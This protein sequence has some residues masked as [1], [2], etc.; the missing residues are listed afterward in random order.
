MCSKHALA[1]IASPGGT[2]YVA[3]TGLLGK[4]AGVCAT[5]IALLRSYTPQCFNTIK[6][7]NSPAPAPKERGEKTRAV[8]NFLPL[9]LA[10][11]EVMIQPLLRQ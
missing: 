3:P 6:E 4:A 10:H 11:I 8:L 5:H 2:A 9:E 7:L 1:P